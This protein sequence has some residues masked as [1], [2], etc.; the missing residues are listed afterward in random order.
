M[1][2]SPFHAASLCT[3]TKKARWI[4]PAQ[5]KADGYILYVPSRW[6]RHAPKQESTLEA[7]QPFIGGAYDND[8]PL[9]SQSE[10]AAVFRR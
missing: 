9:Q 5:Y 10:R 4:I 1:F 3:L 7:G 2:S 8:T 6:I